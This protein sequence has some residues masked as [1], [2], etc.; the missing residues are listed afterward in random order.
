MVIAIIAILAGMLLPALAKAKAREFFARKALFDRLAGVFD[1]AGIDYRHVV[2]AP[3]WYEEGHG[4][5]D[6]N[7]VYL[8]AAEHLFEEAAT[9]AIGKAG[10]NKVRFATISNEG[11]H[12]GRGGQRVD[13]RERP[14]LVRVRVVVGQREEQEVEQVVLDH[15]LADAARVL[16][17]DAR[18]AE[19]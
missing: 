1:N 3:D 8:Q 15:V 14:V 12:A 11:R 7:A 9:A 6:R 4:C 16:I 17:A 2:A 13:L 19:L 18:Q 10:E 5:A